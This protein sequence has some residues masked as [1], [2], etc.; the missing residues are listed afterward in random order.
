MLNKSREPKEK[1]Y[2]NEISKGY[3]LTNDWY[4]KHWDDFLKWVN[5]K[6]IK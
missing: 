3:Y 2:V 1:Y 6:Q 5:I 4:E